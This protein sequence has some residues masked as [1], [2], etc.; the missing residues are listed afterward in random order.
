L[1][2]FEGGLV[3]LFCQD[4][5][6]NIILHI[7]QPF[8]AG[9]LISLSMLHLIPFSFRNFLS[10]PRAFLFALVGIMILSVFGRPDKFLSFTPK[11]GQKALLLVYT[12]SF[13]VLIGLGLRTGARFALVATIVA[14][15][16]QFVQSIKEFTYK[17]GIMEGKI[18]FEELIFLSL[19]MPLIILTTFTTSSVFNPVLINIL[20]SLISMVILYQ[21]IFEFLLSQNNRAMSV[22]IVYFL[23]GMYIV[24]CL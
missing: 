8:N 13:G 14:I 19:V 20:F 16:V 22:K 4:R 7:F 3:T 10:S 1:S 5:G 21:G 12:L 9:A 15:P 18:F 11:W 24:Y 2:H 23:A 17:T 6:R